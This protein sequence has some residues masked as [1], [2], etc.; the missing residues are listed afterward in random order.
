MAAFA[1]FPKYCLRSIRYLTFKSS[2]FMFYQNLIET[3]YVL[4]VVHIYFL[5]G[6]L[7]QNVYN[8]K[9][10]NVSN[11]VNVTNVRNLP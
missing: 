7:T 10:F 3:L 2:S 1:R 9:F 8:G 6:D 11:E 5:T 4:V